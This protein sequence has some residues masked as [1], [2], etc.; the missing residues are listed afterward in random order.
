MSSLT[1]NQKI[2][3]SSLFSNQ[4]PHN[5]QDSSCLL[6]QK[7]HKRTINSLLNKGLLL[8]HVGYENSYSYPYL[9]SL[10]AVD[11]VKEEGL[12]FVNGYHT[13]VCS[14]ASY[15]RYQADPASFDW[16]KED[17]YCLHCGQSLI[18]DCDN[19]RYV[20]IE[21]FVDHKQCRNCLDTIDDRVGRINP[22]KTL[23]QAI[24][25]ALDLN[26]RFTVYDVHNASDRELLNYCFRALAE[27]MNYNAP[28]L[29][30]LEDWEVENHVAWLTERYRENH[31]LCKCGQPAEY[32]D[33]FSDFCG[34][35]P[36]KEIC[37]A[38]RNKLDYP[39]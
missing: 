2:V 3:L 28:F 4:Q 31:S 11:I 35:F 36:K 7:N 5:Y 37:Q 23:Q 29:P 19:Y 10:P 16:R 6:A 12:I 33:P 38:C 30:D 14:L 17:C 27:K 20:R 26:P 34:I 22:N 8:S 13:A 15:K 39:C 1:L 21:G 25:I 9:F 24:P 32:S 18:V